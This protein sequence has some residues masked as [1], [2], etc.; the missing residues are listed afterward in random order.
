M[1]EKIII[2]LIILLILLLIYIYIMYNINKCKHDWKLEKSTTVT[3]YNEHS[4][5]RGTES[6]DLYVC[7]KCGNFQKNITG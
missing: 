3:I 1:L 7:K 2:S 6:I 5:Y 4:E